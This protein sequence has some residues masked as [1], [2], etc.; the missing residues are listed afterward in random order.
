[1]GQDEILEKENTRSYLKKK[2]KKE[3]VIPEHKGHTGKDGK[4]LWIGRKLAC[5]SPRE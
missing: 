4:D 3:K 5:R 1:M 2:R